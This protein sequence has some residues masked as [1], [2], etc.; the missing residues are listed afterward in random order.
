MSFPSSPFIHLHQ[1]S[2]QEN[3]SPLHLEKFSLYFISIALLCPFSS[4]S[5]DQN[6]LGAYVPIRFNV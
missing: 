3:H 2:Y 5:I 6:N 4:V 1:N